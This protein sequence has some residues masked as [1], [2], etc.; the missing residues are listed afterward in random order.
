MNSPDR[1]DQSF[2]KEQFANAP[3]MAAEP[4][5]MDRFEGINTPF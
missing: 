2:S 1:T 4:M 5:R 3:D